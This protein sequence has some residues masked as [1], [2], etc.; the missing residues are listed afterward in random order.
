MT[1]PHK[2]SGKLKARSAVHSC[3]REMFAPNPQAPW[4]ERR[5][6]LVGHLAGRTV[7]VKWTHQTWERD[8][9]R[10]LREEL[11]VLSQKNGPP[12]RNI[13]PALYYLEGKPVPLTNRSGKYTKQLVLTEKGKA[14]L[15]PDPTP[16]TPEPY[17]KRKSGLE[18]LRAANPD[19]PI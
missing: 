3:F 10:A 13:K 6:A 14:L 9:K 17:A 4:R 2:H 15:R 16:H 11:L 19:R 1:S 8:L 7:N 5:V 12:K 18:E